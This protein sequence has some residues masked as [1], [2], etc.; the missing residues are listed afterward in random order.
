LGSVGNCSLIRPSKSLIIVK[1]IVSSIIRPL[2]ALKW[3]PDKVCGN[4]DTIG[5]MC[6]LAANVT[7]NAAIQVKVLARGHAS[8]MGFDR[9]FF[10][11]IATFSMAVCIPLKPLSTYYRDIKQT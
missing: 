5:A 3:R 7:A 11:E 10:V 4:A 1:M 6:E 8:L 9:S 2:D